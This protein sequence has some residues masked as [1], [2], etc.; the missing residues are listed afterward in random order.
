MNFTKF[1]RA[2]TL[3]NNAGWLWL[4]MCFIS[5]SII[6]IKKSYLNG[7]TVFQELFLKTQ[8]LNRSAITIT[9]YILLSKNVKIFLMSLPAWIFSK[10]FWKN[11]PF[12]KRANISISNIF[13]IFQKF[14]G[15]SRC[16]KSFSFRV[17]VVYI[18]LICRTL[19]QELKT[20]SRC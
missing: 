20:F 7:C 15:N 11:C 5:F 19:Q 3:Q 4:P 14:Y 8:S 10:A 2:S 16:I 6:L 1:L 18:T 12:S 13:K 9:V 17:T